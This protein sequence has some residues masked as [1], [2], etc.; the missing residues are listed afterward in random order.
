MAEDMLGKKI[1]RLKEILRELGSFAIAFSGGVDSTFLLAV[2]SKLSGIDIMAITASSPM[3]AYREIKEARETTVRLKVKHTIIKMDLLE[4]PSLKA[5]PPERCY[6]CKKILFTKFLNLAEK[7]G[8]RYLTDGTNHDDLKAYRPGLRALKE[9]GARSPL[10]E[11]GF[12]KEDIRRYSKIM[13]LPAWDAPPLACLA[14]RIPY[15][16]EITAAKLKM[17][18]RAE[19]FIRSLGFRQ[20]RVRYHYPIARI[21]L[22]PA[23]ISRLIE[24][25]MRK[26]TVKR[27]K[28]IGFGHIAIDMEGYRTGSMDEQKD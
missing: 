23:D 6:I 10:A 18:D 28:A 16:E 14:T 21:E 22:D 9:L 20:V 17:I 1:N 5:N 3:S 8:L 26:K 12:T 11:A 2:A 4:S 24:L 15:N 13:G 27:L 7:Q 19:E 25:P